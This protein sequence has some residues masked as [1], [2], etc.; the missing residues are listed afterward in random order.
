[1]QRMALGF[2][3]LTLSIGGCA[4]LVGAAELMPNDDVALAAQEGSTEL[5]GGGSAPAPRMPAAAMDG[6]R[7]AANG[8]LIRP[9]DYREWNYLSSGLGMTYG[10]NAPQPG[11]PRF[12][13]NV[14]VNRESYK[15]FMATGTWL[16]KTTLVLEVRRSQKSV[17]IDG[18]GDSQGDVVALEVEVKDTARF[19]NGGWGFFDFGGESG[20]KQAQPFSASAAC[21]SCHRE[22]TAVDNTFVQFYPTLMRV[23]ERLGTVRTTFDPNRKI[24]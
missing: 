5:D 1:M 18:F 3:S 12:F 17:S 4:D 10:P 13:D 15:H 19:P 9:D 23:A 16:E 22:H 24:K 11:A 7:Y 6:A 14:F 8:T 2:L 20:L 21:Y